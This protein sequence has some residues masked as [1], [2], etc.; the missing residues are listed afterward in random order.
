M[1]QELFANLAVTA[2]VLI[3]WTHASE[4]TSRQG[5]RLRSILFGAAMAA[6]TVG[7]MMMAFEAAPGVYFD[8]RAPLL[9]VTALFGGVPAAMVAATAAFLYRLSLGGAVWAG[10]IQ[11]ALSVGIGLLGCV[12]CRRRTIR[13]V[14]VGILAA[15]IGVSN[16]ALIL[17]L[18]LDSQDDFIRNLWEPVAIV[19]ISTVVLGVVLLHEV[20][21]RELAET[22]MRYRSMVDALPDCLNIKDVEGRFLAA[23][24]ATAALMGAKNSDELVGK[25]DFDFY[26][27]ELARKFRNDELAV[28][29]TGETLIL[30]QDGQLPGRGKTWLSTQ[31][32]PVRDENGKVVGLIT[33]NRDVTTYKNVQK[34]LEQ[35]QTYLDQALENMTDGL[36]MYD[37][38]G[39]F[40]FCNSRYQ[41]M[42][43]RT[44]HLR[45][46]GANF[47]DI[48]R[49][50][51]E[52][53]EERLPTG[54][55]LEPYVATKL[56]RLKT[57]SEST[58]ELSDGRAF[59]SRIKR[60]ENGR[61][62]MLVSDI[63]ERRNYESRLQRQA[64]YDPLTGLPNRAHFNQEFARLFEAANA[65]GG[66]LVVMLLDLDRFKE[67]NDTFGHGVG[68]ELLAEVARRLQRA[69]RRDDLVCRLGGD[70]FAIL[71][72]GPTEGTGDVSLARR[73]I[74]E[75]SRPFRVGDVTL[76][77]GGTIGYTVYPADNSDCQGLLRNAD[78]ALYQAKANGRGTW[79]AFD[80]ISAHDTTAR[81]GG[82]RGI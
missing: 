50:S 40:L 53:G 29:R 30:E 2:I 13:Y 82:S 54:E 72:P 3:A 18:P 79:K 4:R 35:T 58:I 14:D 62:L 31:K 65:D 81:A 68:D 43:P 8:L 37:D 28:L 16:A 7:S 45:I 70:E 44:A 66:E 19:F 46:P 42:F 20:R 69:M 21:R 67:V 11:I 9:A 80:P 61:S 6:G 51:I 49:A 38:N 1:W 55:L 26:P 64:L 33:H 15:L 39:V 27:D 73:C 74:R 24:P 32:V 52:F 56:Q 57:D 23:N 76:L 75:L 71:M 59:S 77:P 17:Q 5:P 25:S 63:T 12:L 41:D 34:R 48:V 60:L 10:G 22:N 78:R 47:A 36:A